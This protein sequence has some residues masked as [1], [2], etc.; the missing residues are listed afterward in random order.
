MNEESPLDPGDQMLTG[1]KAHNPD[2]SRSPGRKPSYIFRILGWCAKYVLPPMILILISLAVIFAIQ[3]NAT[4]VSH[5]LGDGFTLT[6]DAIKTSVIVRNYSP[7][8]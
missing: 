1:I 6:D 8:S 5:T 2:T 4:Q 3:A 7:I